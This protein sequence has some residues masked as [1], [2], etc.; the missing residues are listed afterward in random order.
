[1]K[2]G[3]CQKVRQRKKDKKGKAEEKRGKRH[4]IINKKDSIYLINPDKEE[5]MTRI[6]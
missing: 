3:I 1:L 5:P 4:N 6:G 2:R